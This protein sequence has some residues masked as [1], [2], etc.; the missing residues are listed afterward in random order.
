[1]TIYT[2]FGS[3]IVITAKYVP[4]DGWVNVTRE[5]GSIREYHISE[6]KADNGL[7]EIMEAVN[8]VQNFI[9]D[10]EETEHND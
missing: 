1:M 5:D 3:P 7:T 4:F 9:H 8:Q 10:E 6:L 2:R